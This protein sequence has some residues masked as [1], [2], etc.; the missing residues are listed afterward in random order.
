MS[1]KSILIVGAGALGINTG[2]HL[3]L[4]G[5]DVSFL[6]RPNKL[7]TLSRPQRLYCYND[8]S[9]KTF[10]GY[11]IYTNPTDLHD[12]TFDFVLLTLDGAACRTNDG[13]STLQ[14]LGAALNGKETH[15][16]IWKITLIFT[17]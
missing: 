14:Q 17:M 11:Q 5:A 4:A 16:I 10:D 13:V 9:V 6:V 15:L 3:Q 1:N 8:H 2:Y 12:K 7:E